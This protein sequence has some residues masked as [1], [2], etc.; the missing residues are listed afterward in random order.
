[1]YSYFEDDCIV[2]Y[3]GLFLS[4]AFELSKFNVLFDSMK[5]M[6]T[7]C[8]TNYIIKLKIYV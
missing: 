2:L 8:Y 5:A 1:M 7:G 4:T 6:K 3:T